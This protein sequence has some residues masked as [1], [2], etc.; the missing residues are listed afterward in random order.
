[1]IAHDC[2][3]LVFLENTSP[4]GQQQ[5]TINTTDTIIR[6]TSGEHLYP[7]FADLNQD[8]ED[9]LFISDYLLHRINSFYYYQYN[10]ND[11]IFKSTVTGITAPI[12]TEVYNN[13]EFFDFDNDGDLD[14]YIDNVETNSPDRL[15]I[16]VGTATNPEFQQAALETFG[17]PHISRACEEFIDIDGDGDLDMFHLD[18]S[19]YTKMYRNIGSATEPN[20]ALVDSI[21]NPMSGII[22][23]SYPANFAFA[24]MDND[25]DYDVIISIIYEAPYYRIYKNTGDTNSAIFTTPI[26]LNP[27]PFAFIG[28]RFAYELQPYNF[29]GDNKKDLI[30]GIYTTGDP[31]D[32]SI[33]R[34][35]STSTSINFERMTNAPLG[36]FTT[37]LGAFTMVNLF[38]ES[39]PS[40]I[41]DEVGVGHTRDTIRYYSYSK[42]LHLAPQAYS[43]DERSPQNTFVGRINY[44]Y[45]GD[46]T[47]T[48][49]I[50]AGNND[51]AFRLSVDSILVQSPTAINYDIIAN[52]TF[53]LTIQASDGVYS[54]DTTYT[55][56]VNNILLFFYDKTINIEERLPV[57]TAIGHINSNYDGTETVTYSITAGN[58]DNA[59]AVEGDSIVVQNASA[60]NYDIV[61]NRT[62]NLTIEATDGTVTKTA[63][64]TINLE[65]ITLRI[66]DR[67]YLMH[68]ESSVG[69]IV[70]EVA[71]EYYGT[72]TLELSILSG[73]NADAFEIIDSNIVVKT[74]NA[75]DYSIEANRTFNLTIE[76]REDNNNDTI[77]ET[78]NYT[79]NVT[80]ELLN[81]EARTYA[82]DERS[83]EGTVVGQII[84]HYFGTG[85]VTY[86]ITQGNTDNA[87]QLDGTNI[88]VQN[89][90]ALNYDIEANRTF[91]LTIEATDGTETTTAVYTININD[92][93]TSIDNTIKDEVSI[94]PNPAQDKLNIDIGNNLGD[95]VQLLLI[96]SSGVIVYKQIAFANTIVQI[97]T[98][99]LEAGIYFIE[100]ITDNKKISEKIIIE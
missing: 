42:F 27:D 48:F 55:V 49:D 86:S 72:D 73:N 68:S 71:S 99:D 80:L 93:V 43:V 14:M 81:L 40:I 85:T 74:A 39:N 95:K 78:A 54:V 79:I 87:F 7:V 28:N 45:F 51:N 70:G 5:F 30:V 91:S 17:I 21:N 38:G 88:V 35:T 24:D 15:Y 66:H 32:Y 64:Y 20:F 25:G 46:S 96:N 57:G 94:Y 2:N 98:S 53:N 33:F 22:E 50:T 61:A 8:N 83:A 63:T 29:D 58:N 16:N 82:I 84:S 56:H 13:L 11:N 65:D 19:Q 100:I 1:A 90:E 34:N 47:L 62:F 9:D 4:G 36:E 77:I 10:A 44:N 52:R 12:N 26:T 23:N 60:L 97:N 89:S 41:I 3:D 6:G 75:L 67:T 37:A 59:F 92:V 69:T 18:D 76:A 31:G